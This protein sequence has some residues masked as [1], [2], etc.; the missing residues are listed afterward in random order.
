MDCTILLQENLKHLFNYDE[1]SGFFT[2]KSKPSKKIVIGD[3][4][5]CLSKNGY[6]LIGFNKKRYYAHR[7]VWLYC[8]GK[9][10]KGVIDHINGIKTDNRLCNLR[11]VTKT[12]NG[13]NRKK[14]PKTNK[15]SNDLGI[16]W[17][18]SLKK[19]RSRITVNGK[20][21]HLG[22]FD[23]KE[24]ALSAYLQAKAKYHIES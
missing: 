2:W 17:M 7:L 11:E 20:Q 14:A 6:L 15:F 13:Q 8:Y 5:G 9:F 24:N 4:A 22:I 1:Q 23:N 21:I 10:P 18:V 12:Q 19:W 16:S 3:L